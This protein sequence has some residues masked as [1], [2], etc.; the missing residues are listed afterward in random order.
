MMKDI[1][2]VII[3]PLYTEKSTSLGA[4]SKFAFKVAKK[5]TKKDVKAA[6]EKL[7][8]VK[9]TS[10][11]IST[12]KPKVKFFKGRKGLKGGYKKAIVSLEKGQVIE[13]VKGA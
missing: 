1:Y 3:A 6:I 2:N 8:E 9:V 7:F 11:N 5:A 4:L 13:M 12:S 10:V